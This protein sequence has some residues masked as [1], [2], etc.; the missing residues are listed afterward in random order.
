MSLYP[1]GNWLSENFY[2]T[3]AMDMAYIA[4]PGEYAEKKLTYTPTTGTNS[5]LAG[6]RMT[7]KDCLGVV[8]AGD[9]IHICLTIDYSG[10]DASNTDGTF[11]LFFQGALLKP[12]GLHDWTISNNA[13]SALNSQ[14]SLKSLVLSSSSGSFIYD[15][16]FML[17]DKLTEYI[18]CNIGIR[19]DYS[20]G[21]GTISMSNILIIPEKYRLPLKKCL[22]EGEQYVVAGE[23][24]E[25]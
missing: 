24:I 17:Q 20:N 13:T 3:T 8:N 25:I 18:S 23:F 14:Q 10:F 16:T 2:E 19:A 9:K 11:K 6:F 21:K 22:R 4:V 15:T 12:D 1:T 7:W 5:C